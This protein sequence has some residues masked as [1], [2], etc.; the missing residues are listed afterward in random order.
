MRYDYSHTKKEE[1]EIQEKRILNLE[2]YFKITYWELC[3]N[4]HKQGLFMFSTV[5]LNGLLMHT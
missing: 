4:F 3:K 2:L 1:S 5:F